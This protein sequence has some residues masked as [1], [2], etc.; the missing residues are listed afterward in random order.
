[1]LQETVDPVGSV[2]VVVR[3]EINRPKLDAQMRASLKRNAS[4]SAM[5]S[6]M[7]VFVAR[8]QASITEYDA[9]RTASRENSTTSSAA[10]KSQSDAAAV[11]D[12]QS[13]AQLKAN[14]ATDKSKT[15]QSVETRGKV[16]TS[17]TTSIEASTAA[18][19]KEGG[20]ARTSGSVTLR[21]DTV[22]WR[23]TQASEINQ[24]LS[25]LF[26]QVGYEVVEA[27]YLEPQSKGLISLSAIRSDFGAGDDLRPETLQNTAR[28]AVG[29]GMPFLAYG[30]LD[31]GMRDVDP[32]SG[33]IRVAVTVAAKVV[34]VRG[35]FPVTAASVG[36]VQYFGVGPTAVVARTN[37]LRLA[38]GEAGKLL[39]AEL[40]GKRPLGAR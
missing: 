11:V 6:L 1:M 9:T 18:S 13:A 28:G 33:L 12:V 38:A 36:P 8:E 25:G 10:T 3:V 2:T 21:A 31:V 20:T 7:F 4:S 22:K 29:A 40:A 37:A 26:S 14:N 16:A 27:E 30:T 34:D 15:N 17:V 19:A 39:L 24:V 32:S 5:K 23:V 35:R